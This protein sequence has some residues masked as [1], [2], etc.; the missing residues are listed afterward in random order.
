MAELE[1]Q[2]VLETMN[3]LITKASPKASENALAE[4]SFRVV[5]RMDRFYEKGNGI[6][7]DIPV[8]R[9]FFVGDDERKPAY[10]AACRFLL[11][12][13]ELTHDLQRA[14]I[15]LTDVE[16]DLLR[17]RAT[18]E[19]AI[20]ILGVA[21]ADREGDA[22]EL[23]PFSR[24]LTDIGQEIQTAFAGMTDTR[25][26]IAAFLTDIAPSFC[27]QINAVAD[28]KHRGASCDPRATARLCGELLSA[29]ERMKS[30]MRQM[31]FYKEGE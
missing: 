21:S 27:T 10:R 18:A 31:A 12:L 15:C 8:P 17:V 11:L 28:L 20:E 6:V 5:A 25:A 4:L 3:H 14:L 29:S 13:E 19:R 16:C 22:K 30:V 23:K 26:H 24:Q 9:G 7:T 1:E 2:D